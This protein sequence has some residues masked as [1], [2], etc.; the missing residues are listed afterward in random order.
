[1][2]ELKNLC[3]NNLKLRTVRNELPPGKSSLLFL[4]DKKDY[5]MLATTHDHEPELYNMLKKNEVLLYI[6][7][8][9]AFLD[10]LKRNGFLT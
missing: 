5:M 9:N 10:Y 7:A 4:K 1:M 3:A 2:A 8:K 6:E